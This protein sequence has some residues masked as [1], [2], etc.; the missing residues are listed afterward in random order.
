MDETIIK[1]VPESK[2]LYIEDV[3]DMLGAQPGEHISFTKE[4]QTITIK[5]VKI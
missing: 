2:I 4:G 3:L 5:K 1:K